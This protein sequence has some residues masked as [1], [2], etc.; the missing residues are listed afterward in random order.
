MKQGIEFENLNKL[1]MHVRKI[2]RDATGIRKVNL[3]SISI[4]LEEVCRILNPPIV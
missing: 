3:D 4:L 1:L 2:S